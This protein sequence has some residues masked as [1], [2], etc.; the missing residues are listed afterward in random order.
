MPNRAINQF[1]ALTELQDGDLLYTVRA[2]TDY[3][4]DAS[5]FGGRLLMVETVIPTA[6]ML[7]I[8]DT[9]FTIVPAPAADKVIV[10]VLTVFQMV[11]GGTPYT[12][13]GDLETR[14]VGG[15]QLQFA[16]GTGFYGDADAMGNTGGNAVAGAALVM[17]TTDGAD[18]TDGDYDCRVLTYYMIVDAD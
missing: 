10:P 15:A 18:P 7:D 14:T 11:D 6:S 13:S 16:F 3:K 1:P 17:T 8:G 4:V 2:G 12:S 5:T 9:P